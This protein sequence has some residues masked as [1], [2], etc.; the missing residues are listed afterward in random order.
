[1]RIILQPAY[2]LHHRPY[3]ETS[4]LI[5][6]FTRDYGRI[7]GVIRGVR[8]AKSKTRALIQVFT[9]ILVTWQGKGDLVSI[10]KVEPHAFPPRLQGECLVGGLY[11]HEILVRLL[12][13][14]D[15]YPELYTFY[16]K[17]L[18]ELQGRKIDQKVLRLFEKNLLEQ[19]GYGLQLQ[20][21]AYTLT[22]ISAAVWYR[23]IPDRGFQY[24]GGEIQDSKRLGSLFKG[25]SLL[26][27]AK[28]ALQNEEVLQDAKRLMRLALSPLLGAY[29]LQ[30]RL[31][32]VR[33]RGKYEK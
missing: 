23:F 15:P 4:V 31:L 13:K 26:S 2:V 32:F 17:T 27:I 21:E 29:P 28:D 22:P 11:I 3:R 20:H 33:N 10:Y 7:S 18:L 5:D 30:S 6:L 12:H 16:Q 14:H 24:Y 9:P 8:Q 1:M 19:I 25:E